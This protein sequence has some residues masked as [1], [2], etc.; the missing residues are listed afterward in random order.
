MKYIKI[1]AVATV[2]L[3]LTGCGIDLGSGCNWICFS[4]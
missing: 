2:V 3:G 1:L 4:L